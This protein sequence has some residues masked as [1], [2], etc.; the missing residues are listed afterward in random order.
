MNKTLLFIDTNIYLDFY[1]LKNDTSIKLLSKLET[2]KDR[3]IITYI[4]Q[5]EFLKN[6][7]GVISDYHDSIKGINRLPKL[8]I[9]SGL[10]LYS[11]IEDDIK[12]V[13]KRIEDLREVV[14]RLISK[15]EDN[16]TLYLSMLRLWNKTDSCS[17]LRNSSLRPRIEKLAKERF[18]LGS[19]PRKKDDTSC[20][21]AMNWEWLVEVAASSNHDVII[22][23]RDTDYGCVMS[24][25]SQINDYLKYEFQERVGE[26]NSVKLMSKLTEALKEMDVKVTRKQ[27]TDESA[28]I[29]NMDIQP[30]MVVELRA[31]SM[32]GLRGVV[33]K[34]KGQNEAVVNVRMLGTSVAVACLKSDLCRSR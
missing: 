6:R 17:L 11:E 5:M 9:L 20:G 15:P 34:L 31:G 4:I 12:G 24:E 10:K 23:S 3:I 16:D 28:I 14:D 7:Q 32:A 2:I 29:D 18:E 26:N 19:P 22:V 33:Q 27:E 25:G 13:N 1:R 21:D 30:G 8:P